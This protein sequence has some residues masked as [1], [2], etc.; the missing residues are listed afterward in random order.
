MS[1]WE[2]NIDALLFVTF[3]QKPVPIIARRCGE[4]EIPENE[5]ASKM[6]HFQMSSVSVY[7][8]TLYNTVLSFVV[9]ANLGF[10]YM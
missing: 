6:N 3:L 9:L 4:R 8:T 2:I 7:S 5:R 1:P 10:G